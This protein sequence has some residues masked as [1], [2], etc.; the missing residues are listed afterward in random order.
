MRPDFDRMRCLRCLAEF[1]P[2]QKG[3]RQQL[4]N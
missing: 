3:Q 2:E 1:I 4:G